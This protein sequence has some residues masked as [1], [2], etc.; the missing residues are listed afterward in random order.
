[1]AEV[2]VGSWTILSDIISEL[3]LVWVVLGVV[4]IVVVEE[5]DPFAAIHSRL[6]RRDRD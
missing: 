6:E 5:V 4:V 1:M 2:S 3:G